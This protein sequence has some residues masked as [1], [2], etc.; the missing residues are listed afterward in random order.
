MKTLVFVTSHFPF[1]TGESFIDAEFPILSQNFDKV[2]IIAQNV[3]DEKTRDISGNVLVCRYNI[4]T[5]LWGFIKMPFL[6]IL[7]CFTVIK[8]CGEE[9]RFRRTIE[10]HITVAKFPTLLKRIIKSLQLRDFINKKLKKECISE[11]I[12]FYS[13]WLKTSSIA[14]SMLN[15]KA[16]IKVSRAH[17]SDIYEEKTVKGYL[18][19]LRYNSRKLDAIFFISKN[20]KEYFENK[21]KDENHNFFISYLGVTKPRYGM[22]ETGRSQKYTIVSCSNMIP[23]KRI[24]LIINAFALVRSER[25][26]EWLHFGTGPLKD[27]LEALACRKLER[28]KGKHYRFMGQYPNADLL[29]YYSLNYIDLFINTSFTEG[30][31]VSIME[32]QAFGIPVI[33]TDV[34][35]VSE[36]VTEETGTLLTCDLST[37]VLAERIQ[38]YANLSVK[39][40]EKI[41]KNAFNNWELN[42]NAQLN[43]RDFIIKL[44]TI[45]ASAQDSIQ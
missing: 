24:D 39:E 38:Y 21:I 5:S 34:G 10:N 6:I 31:P 26:I 41:R 42:F 16:S 30:V 33:A 20:G 28:S 43:Y 3:N 35:G 7:N 18:P 1:G 17:G 4:S 29:E 11:S 23:L 13:Y 9:I 25:E 40:V 8:L 2:I 12:V 15:Y 22:V 37:E 45:F 36:L 44:N 32:A 14:I 27:E 19:L